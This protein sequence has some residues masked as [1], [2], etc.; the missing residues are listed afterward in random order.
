MKSWPATLPHR[1]RRRGRV[2]WQGR[3]GRASTK[4]GGRGGGG[5]AGRAPAGGEPPAP[6]A[7]VVAPDCRQP[8]L[9]SL[10]L[11]A[12]GARLSEG[13]ALAVDAACA[14]SVPGLSGAG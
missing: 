1:W 8:Y 9:E 12:L 14:S 6:A 13:G 11:E 7:A 4:R 10:G 3:R 5:G 2:C